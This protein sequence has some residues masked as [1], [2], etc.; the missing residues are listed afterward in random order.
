MVLLRR[1]ISFPFSLN[2]QL[3]VLE[4][5]NLFLL[6]GILILLGMH[7]KETDLEGYRDSLASLIP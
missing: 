3:F 7:M 5:L 4:I 6:G 2:Y 1:R